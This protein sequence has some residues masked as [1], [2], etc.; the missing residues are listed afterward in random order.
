MRLGVQAL[1]MAACTYAQRKISLG[2]RLSGTLADWRKVE[3]VV[4]WKTATLRCSTRGVQ[5][6]RQQQELRL[7]IVSRPRCN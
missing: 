7:L 1:A 3:H 4:H 6:C 5:H 2:A